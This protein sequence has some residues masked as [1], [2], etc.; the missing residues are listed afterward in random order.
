MTGTT[1]TD[2]TVADD[3]ESYD[4]SGSVSSWTSFST[5]ASRRSLIASDAQSP[6]PS[7]RASSFKP[8]FL[9]CLGIAI[10][11]RD[12]TVIAEA[13]EEALFRDLH[14][15]RSK[16]SQAS[17][18]DGINM[19]H[20]GLK[21]AGSIMNTL[22][23]DGC[24]SAVTSESGIFVLP[25]HSNAMSSGRRNTLVKAL[26][27]RDYTQD[28]KVVRDE[29]SSSMQSLPHRLL[30][31]HQ[32]GSMAAGDVCSFNKD[33]DEN[34]VHADPGIC[35]S[36][37][38]SDQALTTSAPGMERVLSKKLIKQLSRK[39]PNTSLQKLSTELTAKYTT[40]AIIASPL[41]S[42]SAQ[43]G[44]KTVINEELESNE[45]TAES[46][47]EEAV[48]FPDPYGPCTAISVPLD[49]EAFA[50]V[51]AALFVQ[52]PQDVLEGGSSKHLIIGDATGTALNVKSG[53]MLQHAER[54]DAFVRDQA[55]KLH[56]RNRVRTF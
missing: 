12:L 52:A 55:A 18:T 7:R 2:G 11:D 6:E 49:S 10:D 37:G 41:A 16:L 4:E 53:L 19:Q 31:T 48:R 42:I 9:S 33:Y 56:A 13:S 21:Y 15:E 47:L 36:N 50:L 23:E 1:S 27:F 20:T 38:L 24:T 39:Q 40:R 46:I 3:S 34:T 17:S 51:R 43:P 54:T 25:S 35:L 45:M 30:Q 44:T 32:P 5:Q 14:P 22:P 8:S 29:P 26:S 28:D